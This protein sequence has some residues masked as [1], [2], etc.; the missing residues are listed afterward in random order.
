M[1]RFLPYFALVAVAL[2]LGFAFV[3][4]SGDPLAITVSGDV[5]YLDGITDGRS[6]RA[7][8]RLVAEHPNVKTLILRHVPGTRDVTSNYRL[9][10]SIREAGLNTKITSSSLIASGGVDL[11]LA[12]VERTAQC[13]AR[14]GVHS[15]GSAG[16]DAQDVGWDTH[17]A[18]SRDF[19]QDMGI[20]P[21]FYDFR[22]KKAGSD[23]IH[24]MNKAEIN[25]WRLTTVPLGCE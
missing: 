22:T 16:Y 2:M 17:R 5:A 8:P 24:W 18:Y 3:S 21:D 25:R 6:E 9:A 12:G 11:F 14:I 23:E 20:D 15:W 10:R 13:G 19:L 7:V 4:R 1:I